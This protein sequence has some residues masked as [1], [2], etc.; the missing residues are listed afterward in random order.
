VNETTPSQ[1][2]TSVNRKVP[3]LWA[4]YQVQKDSTKVRCILCK[5][6]VY[7]TAFNAKRHIEN[8]HKDHYEKL[9]HLFRISSTSKP[10]TKRVQSSYHT[11]LKGLA[12]TLFSHRIESSFRIWK[13]NFNFSNGKH[14]QKIKK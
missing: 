8:K 10:K 2:N 14:F 6:I 5:N 12:I 13:N 9:K 1:G 7:S 11:Y 3:E 4:L